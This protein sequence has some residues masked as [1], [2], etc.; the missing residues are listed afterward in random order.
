MELIGTQDLQEF[1]E[2]FT[3]IWSTNVLLFLDL[4]FHLQPR[5]K[6]EGCAWWIHYDDR[7]EMSQMPVKW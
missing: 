1:H 2:I 4:S 3:T 5:S 6:C 7:Q